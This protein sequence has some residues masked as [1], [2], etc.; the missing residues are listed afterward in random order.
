M[1]DDYNP[2]ESGSG[3]WEPEK[4]PEKQE[5]TTAVTAFDEYSETETSEETGKTPETASAGTGGNGAVPPV[6]EKKKDGLALASMILGISSAAICVVC[7]CFSFF[8]W[9]TSIACGIAGVVLGIISLNK[10]GRNGW[11]ISGVVLGAVGAFL[12]IVS[13]AM[14]AMLEP[15]IMDFLRE[16]YPEFEEYY[17]YFDS[18]RETLIGFFLR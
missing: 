18:G 17:P 11:A 5:E 7:C 15:Y 9:A 3:A 6:K 10:N 12:A 8:S 2:F 1:S 13:F 16:Y 4:K 14:T